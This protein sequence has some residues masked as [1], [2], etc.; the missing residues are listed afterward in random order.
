MS[1][2]ANDIGNEQQ[3]LFDPSSTLT[4]REKKYLDKSW[5][6]YFAEHIFPKIDERPFAVLYSKKDSRPNTPVNIQVGALL[7][8]QFTG[9][10]DDEI[11]TSLMFDVRFRYALHTTTYIE[12]PLNDRS[13]GR[14]RERCAVYEEETGIDLLHPVINSLSS[15]MAEMMKI[16]LSLKRMDS[17]MVESNIKR[18]GRL[19]LLYTCV[20]NLANEVYKE[21]KQLPENLLHYTEKD[22]RNRVLYHTRSEETADKINTVLQDAKTLKD[23]CGEDF[24]ESSNYRLL[25]RVL[26]EQA[27]EQEDG[28]YRLRTK[29][30]GG[31]DAGILQ[32]PSDPDA[33]F[34]EKAGKQHRGYVANVTEARGENGSIVTDYQYE[35]NT[36]SDSQFLKDSIEAMGEQPETV[37]VVT[38][39]AYPSEEAQKMADANN[40]QLEATNL[41]GRK[42]EDIIAE[43]E[44]NE[45][46][47]KV[48]KC[49]CGYEPKSCSYNSQT[50]QCVVSF[51]KNQCMGCPYKEQCHPKELRRV[52]RKTVS[53]KSKERAI[54][55]RNRNSEEFKK[56]S[57]F[58]NGVE[59]IP[60][61]LRRKYRIDHMPVRGKIRT[62]FFFGC[63]IFALNFQKFC[64]YMQSQEKC[65]QNAAIA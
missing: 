13:L 43:F 31:M 58:R 4:E 19:E 38:D 14:F 54:Q 16:D 50:G 35:Q 62:K 18:M 1:F 29:E 39:G 12:Q 32:N 30:D 53:A 51:Q 33:T 26:K 20:A 23:L 36:Y 45:D 27:V 52:C 34:R 47:T 8:Q 7:I 60:S 6:K 15:E 17:L 10:S 5:A 2:V 11:L 25:L 41:T 64:K 55:Q 63:K 65:A 49:P 40:I 44:F 28:S 21:R 22:D 56:L 48:V 46:G 37:T 3:Y 61:I 42:T 57:A 59:T 24:D 9:L